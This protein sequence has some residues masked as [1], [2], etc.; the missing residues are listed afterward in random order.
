MTRETV[1]KL[2]LLL[3]GLA[4]FG[5]GVRAEVPEVRWAGIAIIALGLLLRFVGRDRTTRD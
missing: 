4:V 3:V 5:Y 2:A 1:I